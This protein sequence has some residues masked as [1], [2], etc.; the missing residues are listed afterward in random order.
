MTLMVTSPEMD[1]VTMIVNVRL[2]TVVLNAPAVPFVTEMPEA[3]KPMTSSLNVMV[4]GID[5]RFVGSEAVL[6]IVAVGGTESYVRLKAPAVFALLAASV[7]TP[8]ATF[9]V[10]APLAVGVSLA[11]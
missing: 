6:V 4:T 2:F 1:G 3:V 8:A 5:A 7:A 9:T 10:T 11:V